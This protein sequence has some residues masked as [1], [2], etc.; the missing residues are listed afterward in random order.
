MDKN[1]L[2]DKIAV[3][4]L[5]NAIFFPR[6]I[7]PLNIF[8]ER[9]IQ[10]VSDSM[11]SQRLFGMI[12]PKIK[13]SKIPELYSVGCLG[14]IISFNETS[15]KRFII[16]L[17][18][19]IRFKIKKE[20]DNKKLYRE[21]EVDYDDFINDLQSKNTKSY[22]ENNLLKKIK[23]FYKKINYLIE[24]AELEKLSFD[25]L[26]ST[27]CMISPFTIEEKQKLIETIEIEDK[28]KIL[29]NIIN[30]NLLDNQ[31]NKTIQ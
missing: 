1:N 31:E 18:G 3:F 6:T 14:K 4:P 8:E 30:F 25:Q 5:S 20:L 17:S 2:P 23:I 16:N 9:Y 22:K 10:L 29:E 15:D 26:V 12:Q 28:I 21:F 13:K 24:F 11:K 7:L 19:V 27:I